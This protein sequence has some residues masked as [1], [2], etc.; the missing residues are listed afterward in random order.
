[1]T[2]TSPHE[3]ADATIPP[4]SLVQALQGILTHANGG[5]L[6]LREVVDV[7]GE[8]GLALVVL[9]LTI[10][11]LL[12]V[13]T[14]GLSAPAGAAVV[15]YGF[16]VMLRLKPWLPGY[17]A[18]RQISNS[19]LE[20]TV[21]FAARISRKVEKLMRPRLKFML[22]PGVNIL[23]GLSLI[24]SGIFLA[25]PIPLPFANA[26]PALAIVLLLCG[27]MERDGVFVIA[28]QIVAVAT[29]AIFAVG[30]Y[31]IIRYGWEGFKRMTGMNDETA[32]TQPG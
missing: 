31:L 23:I 10:P 5:P 26:I 22:W 20:H 14:M 28:G 6:T 11:F 2:E 12:P 24:F 17:L 30:I 25:L 9:V 15:I 18:R 7:V 32:A 29:F 4:I 27:V 8:R 13:P 16:S 21:S 1:M 3:K 19:T